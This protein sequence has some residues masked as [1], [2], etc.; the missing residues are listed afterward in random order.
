MRILLVEDDHNLGQ[1]TAEGLRESYAVDWITNGEDAQDAL[2]TTNYA[3]V[4]LDINL[5]EMSGLDLLTSLRR[6]KN[7]IPVL[8]LTARDALHHKVEGL[9]AGADDYL[10]KPFD[11]DELLARCAALIRRSKGNALPIIEYQNIRYEPASSHLE[12]NG[13]AVN[14]SGRER[15]VFDCLINNIGRTVSK[16]KITESVYDWSSDDIES[17]TIEVHIASLRRKLGKD[18]IKTIRGVGYIIPP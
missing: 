2:E 12:I 14:L 6:N 17:N 3:L 1:A 16:D 7:Q 15:A 8:L 9:N 4:V 13:I 11:L 5:P 10:V 18:T